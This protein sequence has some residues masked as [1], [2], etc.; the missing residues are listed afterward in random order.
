MPPRTRHRPHARVFTGL[1]ALSRDCYDPH[2][3]GDHR[4]ELTHF[5]AAGAARMVA[6][7]PKPEVARGATAIARVVM[8]PSTLARIEAGTLGKGDVLG[9]ARLAAIMATKTTAG[10][11][12]LC[13]PVRITAVDV[14]FTAEPEAAA[15][16]I[17][18]TVEAFDRT[19][20]DMEAMHAASVAAL[21]IY[22]MCKAVDREMRIEQVMLAEKWG[23]K[24][25]HFVRDGA[26]RP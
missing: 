4:D 11:I 26:T 6:I 2:M 21:T 13:H 22:D 25:G 5:D 24:S 15:I 20:P 7:G 1:L 23:G 16:A 12:P 3:S 18:V 14:A 10:A 17:R 9:V 19:G 8:Q